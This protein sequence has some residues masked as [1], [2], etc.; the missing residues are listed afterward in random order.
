MAPGTKSSTTSASSSSAYKVGS[1]LPSDWTLKRSIIFLSRTSLDWCSS[2]NSIQDSINLFSFVQDNQKEKDA[3]V[4]FDHSLYYWAY[5]DR[6]APQQ[7]ALMTKVLPKAREAKLKPEELAG[8]QHF[9]S[10]EEQWKQAIRSVY[11]SVRNNLTDEFYYINGEFSAHFRAGK[12]TKSGQCEAVISN[13]TRGL[14]KSLEGEGIAFE[15]CTRKK[16]WA[17]EALP[18][19]TKDTEQE[20]EEMEQQQ[21]GR[22]IVSN[23]EQEESS[24]SLHFKGHPGVHGVFDYLLN[25][26]DERANRRAAQLPILLS[27]KPFLHATLKSLEIVKNGKILNNSSFDSVS[28]MQKVE[29]MYRLELVGHVLPRTMSILVELMANRTGMNGFMATLVCDEKTIGLNDT[30]LASNDDE[31]EDCRLIPIRSIG[32]KDGQ[33]AWK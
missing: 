4:A 1:S 6:P 23:K 22:T 2:Q 7:V 21:P 8:L 15:V 20:L 11:H 16:K 24:P 9:Q 32:Y 13:A 10:C 12:S 3:K 17:T 28:G 31:D 30:L 14:R 18:E 33:F 26:R 29:T 19:V 5:I 27:H 25:W